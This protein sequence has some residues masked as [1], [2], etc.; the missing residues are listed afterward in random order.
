M[1]VA[2][3]G[4][5]P[6]AF[7]VAQELERELA[8]HAHAEVIY[9]APKELLYLP[10]Y[11]ILRPE[12]LKISALFRYV[13]V[14]NESVNSISLNAQ[15]VITLKDTYGFDVIFIDQ[16]PWYSP[17]DLEQIRSATQNLLLQLHLAGKNKGAAVRFA[18]QGAPVWQAAL[19]LKS[20]LNAT[21]VAGLTVAVGPPK[22]KEVE[23]F[24]K[25]AG[26]SC[27]SDSRLPGFTVTAP[28]PI[29]DPRKIKGGV[30]DSKG[31]LISDARAMAKGQRSVLVR[32][33]N[34]SHL[35]GLYRAERTVA[36]RYA[37]QISRL[38]Q[39]KPLHPEIGDRQ[40][41]LL[42]KSEHGVLVKLDPNRQEPL[43]RAQLAYRLDRALYRRL[44]RR[45]HH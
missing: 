34:Q 22:D 42:L 25:E 14:I 10:E 39:G 29:V 32:G 36:G 6:L 9:F 23:A 28:G 44:L 24:L 45:S 2:I 27:S 30:V 17:E 37:S 43:W 13:Q 3:V 15:R 5:S 41:A 26:I 20:H 4:R 38:N 18:G 1:R 35:C 7:F 16:T 19:S 8:R 11:K 12:G 33:S 21:R 40:A 31:Y